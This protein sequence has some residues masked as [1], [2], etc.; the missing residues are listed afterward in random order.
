[1][2]EIITKHEFWE[3]QDAGLVDSQRIDL[4]GIQDG[5]ILSRTRDV[6]GKRILEIGGGN[7]RILRALA[8]ESRANECWNAERFE[9]FGNGPRV[10]ANDGRIRHANCFVGEFDP[11]LPDA[12]FDLVVSVSVVE[13]V[14][15]DFLESF[16]ADTARVLRP[17]GLILHAID[18]YLYDDDAAVA[19]DDLTR[20]RIRAYR[21]FGDRS[22]LRIR[23]SAEPAV[24]EDASFRCHYASNSDLAM[25]QWNRSVPELKALREVAQSVSIKAEWTRY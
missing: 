6:R 11:G 5:Y 4:K 3:W 1:M 20:Q 19:R 10:N 2:F 14:P 24:D 17:G 9:G 12:Y 18:L 23:F 15:N 22:D 7:S 13:H 16:F 21:A 25:N 8:E